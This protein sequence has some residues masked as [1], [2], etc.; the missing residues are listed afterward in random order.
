VSFEAAL[1]RLAKLRDADLERTWTWP[2]KGRADLRNAF[3]FLLMEE[4]A[5]LVTAATPTNESDRILALAQRAFG[6][7]R[8]LLL[9]VPDE[10]LDAEPAP[11]EWSIRRTMEHTIQVERS[12]RANAQHALLRRDDEPLTIPADRRPKPD[13]A[14]T[15]GDALAIVAALARRRSETDAALAGT[16]AAQLSRPS[17]YSA[18]DAPFDVDVGFRLHRF[19]V[20][21]IEHTQQVEKTL[22]AL[23]QSETDAQ[24]YVRQISILR[25]RHE[26]RSAEGVRGRLDEAVTAVAAGA[27]G[28]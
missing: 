3:F 20:H 1:R 25:A 27:A 7:L 18:A 26:R 16:D 8:G 15:A 23:G 17:Q 4:Q 12:Y 10:V 13:P 14:D 28:G 21:L 9:A 24:A 5:A 11:G 2:G 6:D 22:R 19:G